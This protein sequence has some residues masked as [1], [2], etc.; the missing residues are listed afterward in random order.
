MIKLEKSKTINYLLNILNN[1]VHKS[2]YAQL[3]LKFLWTDRKLC[4]H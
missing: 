3:D 2:K 4:K 1:L